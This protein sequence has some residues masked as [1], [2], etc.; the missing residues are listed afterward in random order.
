MCLPALLKL[1]AF[2]NYFS[3][4]FVDV[5]DDAKQENKDVPTILVLT[6]NATVRS[7]PSIYH[8]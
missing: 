2:R 6:N 3:A 5:R 1:Y 7:A 8:T 4:I